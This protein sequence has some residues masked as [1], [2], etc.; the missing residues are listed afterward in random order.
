MRKHDDL[1]DALR[2]LADFVN[3]CERTMLVKA[4]YWIV[5]HD[6]LVREIPALL[7]RRK[8]DRKSQ[9]VSVARAQRILNDGLPGAGDAAVTGTA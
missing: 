8:E 9:A 6:N 5:D 2:E 1:R 7:K 4:R 3:G